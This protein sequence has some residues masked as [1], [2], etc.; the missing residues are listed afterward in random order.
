MRKFGLLLA[1]HGGLAQSTLESIEMLMGPQENVETVGLYPGMGGDEL[2]GIMEQKLTLLADC[3]NIVIAVDLV[4]GT[5]ANAAA[6]LVAMRP[7]LQLVGGFNLAFLLEL[8]SS[9]ELSETSLAEWLEAGA[10]GMQDIGARL[11]ALLGTGN[12]ATTAA[13][14]L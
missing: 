11:R 4:G 13:N 7:E 14:E 9:E 10:I 12:D 1:A 2:R 6:E 5:P 8:A 3:D